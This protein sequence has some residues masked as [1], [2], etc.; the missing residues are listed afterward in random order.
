MKPRRQK[1]A[2]KFDG[3]ELETASGALAI[4]RQPVVRSR[5]TYLADFLTP[6]MLGMLIALYEHRGVC[7]RR[8]AGREFLRPVGA[9]NWAIRACDHRSNLSLRHKSRH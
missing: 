7:R 2:I 4:P 6:E 9:W 3:A 1:V 8:R 5:W